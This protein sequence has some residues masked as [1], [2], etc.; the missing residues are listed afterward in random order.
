[1]RLNFDFNMKY[2]LPLDFYLSASTTFN[3]DNKPQTGAET[4]DYV[5]Q[6]GVGWEF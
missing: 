2:D 1:V 5:V 4:S 3:Y 6:A